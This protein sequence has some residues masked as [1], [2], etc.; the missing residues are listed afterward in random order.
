MSLSETCFS[1]RKLSIR[2]YH[3]MGC[4]GMGIKILQQD[5]ARRRSLA[6]S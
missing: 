3:E 5:E 4:I 6:I 2:L 1:E